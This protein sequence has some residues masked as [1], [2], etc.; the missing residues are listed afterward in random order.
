MFVGEGVVVAL[1]VVGAAAEVVAVCPQVT[2]FD[3][4]FAMA[5]VVVAVV[6]IVVSV[7]AAVLCGFSVVCSC[8]GSVAAPHGHCP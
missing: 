8:H 1:V 7:V 2:C 4:A 3:V 5:V 6:V